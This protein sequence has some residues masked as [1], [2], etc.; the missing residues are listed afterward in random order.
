MSASD[1]TALLVQR[2]ASKR[3]HFPPPTLTLLLGQQLRSRQALLQEIDGYESLSFSEVKTRAEAGELKAQILLSGY[4]SSGKNCKPSD[5]LSTFWM[6]KAAEQGHPHAQV[7]LALRFAEGEGVKASPELFFKW[8]KSAAKLDP[9]YAP[10]VEHGQFFLSDTNLVNHP[11]INQ[12]VRR[13]DDP[14]WKAQ[15]QVCCVC[16]NPC[17]LTCANCRQV[18]YCS[19]QCQRSDWQCHRVVCRERK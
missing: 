15:G 13:T 14:A 8:I 1:F 3:A 5:V 12:L 19:R 16:Q 7:N 11:T 17:E 18:R 2:M 10:M 6:E 9:L 4:Y